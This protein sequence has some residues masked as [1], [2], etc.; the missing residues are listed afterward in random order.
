MIEKKRIMSFGGGK[1]L[2]TLRNRKK[3]EFE[4]VAA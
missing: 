1:R 2:E 4:R 3:E